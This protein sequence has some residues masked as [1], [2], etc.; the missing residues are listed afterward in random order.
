MK[1]VWRGRPPKVARDTL[2][3][4]A[5]RGGLKALV[6]VTMNKANRIAWIGRMIRRQE[7]TFVQALQDRI[8]ASLSDIA[9]VRYDITR[10]R[11]RRIP[12]YYKEMFA[13]FN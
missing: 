13:W 10:I 3:M 1:F 4:K 7:N 6:L 11:A 2:S 9:Q 8:Q 12:E 5:E